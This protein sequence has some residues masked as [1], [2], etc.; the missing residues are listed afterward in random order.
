MGINKNTA[1]IEKGAMK[2]ANIK[3]DEINICELGN[4]WLT[5]KRQSGKEYYKSLAKKYV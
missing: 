3:Y 4:Q 2:K 5:F 1:N